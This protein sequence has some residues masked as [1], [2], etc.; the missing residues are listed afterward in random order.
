M[1]AEDEDL[2]TAEAL[3]EEENTVLM[4]ISE[5]AREFLITS[6]TQCVK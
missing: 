3:N 1:N 6:C 4:D 5:D 2:H